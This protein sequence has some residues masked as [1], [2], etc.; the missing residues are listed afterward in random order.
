MKRNRNIITLRI[1]TV[2]V[3]I[4]NA[5]ICYVSHSVLP[6]ILLPL[7]T[8]DMECFSNL[9]FVILSFIAMMNIVSYPS[10]YYYCLFLQISISVFMHRVYGKCACLCF[11]FCYVELGTA[12]ACYHAIWS[13]L[14]GSL[15]GWNGNLFLPQQTA[16]SN[17]QRTDAISVLRY[18]SLAVQTALLWVVC[19]CRMS[20]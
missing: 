16:L 15:E 17:T 13:P 10:R 14:G 1:V 20:L 6:W 2:G 19:G 8:A 12:V 3:S 18:F 7:V 9:G 5:F 4:F 11:Y